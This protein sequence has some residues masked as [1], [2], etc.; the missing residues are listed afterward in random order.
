MAQHKLLNC[1]AYGCE[2]VFTIFFHLVVYV[3]RY[4]GFARYLYIARSVLRPKR[5]YVNV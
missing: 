4:I 1:T 2:F 3:T 5:V